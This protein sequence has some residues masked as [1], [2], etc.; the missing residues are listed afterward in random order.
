MCCLAGGHRALSGGNTLELAA[1]RG[2]L[3]ALPGG[4]TLKGVDWH[5][6]RKRERVRP[7]NTNQGDLVMDIHLTERALCPIQTFIHT[8]VSIF[9]SA[10]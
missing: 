7:S 1:S 4:A 6:R 2:Q 5:I 9:S 3:E 8:S 10:G